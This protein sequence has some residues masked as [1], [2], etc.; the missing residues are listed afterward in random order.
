[1]FFIFCRRLRLATA[2][3]FLTNRA[4][5]TFSAGFYCVPPEEKRN[6][7]NPDMET[8]LVFVPSH[9]P[10]TLGV[11][12]ELQVLD[13]N[14][15]LLTPRAHELIARVG[16][17]R[18]KKEFFQSTL[19]VV[20]A[21]CAS[22]HEAH[23][24][25][26][27]SLNQVQHAAGQLGLKI[28][29]TGTH[30]EADYRDRLITP[31]P[32]YTQ[33]ADRN[34][35]LIRRMAV[36]GM[37]IHVGMPSADAAIAF[38]NFL[39]HFVPHVLALSASSP[40]WQRMDT[41]LAAARP[42]MYE[43]MPTCGM[44]YV[45]S[46]WKQFQKLYAQLV[47]TS[48]IKTMHDL[49]W[50]VRP[51]PKLGTVELRICDE[52]A[53]LNEASAIVAFVHL[54]AYWF[55]DHHA[56]WHAKNKSVRRWVLR[57]NKWRAVRFGLEAEIIAKPNRRLVALTEDIHYWLEKLSPYVSRFHYEAFVGRLTSLV[58]HGNSAARQRRKFRDAGSL[59]DVTRHNVAEFEQ[60]LN[61]NRPPGT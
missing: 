53:T 61:D 49:W 15:L 24:D 59:Q 26:L 52:P 36:Y 43:S 6:D 19:E 46:N 33:L 34:Q 60:C 9:Q 25:L 12:L 32:R 7:E 41:G 55:N 11:E 3:L 29:S 54:L 56:E 4:K 21:I 13:A 18:L 10:F 22:A 44:P 30:P 20:T 17:D 58:T 14:D 8:P 2:R 39:L 23:T 27:S 31:S 37:H 16:S 35:W 42:T 1:M 47:R 57:E 28:S 45:V 51:S 50:D 40:F 5:D 38:N 48:S